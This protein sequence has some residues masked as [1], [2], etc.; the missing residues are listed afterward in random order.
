MAKE[1]SQ[2]ENTLWKIREDNVAQRKGGFG[3]CIGYDQGTPYP[4][5]G[6]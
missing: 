3:D 4:N 5:Y 2:N 1:M 6:I